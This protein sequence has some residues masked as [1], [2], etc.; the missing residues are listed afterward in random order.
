MNQTA[1]TP[2]YIRE[3]IKYLKFVLIILVVYTHSKPETAGT[4]KTL[5]FVQE[6]ITYNF[7]ATAVPLFFLISGYLFFREGTLN[8]ELYVSKLKKRF[9]TLVIPYVFWILGAV[10]IL[11]VAQKYLPNLFAGSFPNVSTFKAK[12]WLDI[13]W[14]HPLQYQFWFLRDLFLTIL[15]TPLIYLFI[16]KIGIFFLLGLLVLLLARPSEPIVG[17]SVSVIFYFSIGAFFAIKNID[18]IKLSDKY[19]IPITIIYAVFFLVS[20]IIKESNPLN[21]SALVCL[22]LP[23]MFFMVGLVFRCRACFRKV[24]EVFYSSTFFLYAF[25]GLFIIVLVR[26]LGKIGLVNTDIKAVGVYLL[27]PIITIVVSV[28][29][30]RLLIKIAPRFT[31][32]IIGGR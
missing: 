22:I 18:F 6:I 23:G 31:K 1:T 21:F 26:L 8:K 32:L 9:R 28:L 2:S 25:H 27:A 10:V 29:V 14:I 7:C 30:Y 15:L 11:F 17:F 4:F 13:F 24:P 12:D 3:T 19:F 20:A 16:R 5:N